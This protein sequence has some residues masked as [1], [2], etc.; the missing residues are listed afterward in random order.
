V[1]CTPRWAGINRATQ[2]F[3]GREEKGFGILEVQFRGWRGNGSGKSLRSCED[4]TMGLVKGEEF[5]KR[6]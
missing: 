1:V 6:C 3:P 5:L 4:G 2:E